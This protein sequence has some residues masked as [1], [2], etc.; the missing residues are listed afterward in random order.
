LVDTVEERILTAL[1]EARACAI[2]GAGRP[3]CFGGKP[4]S[5]AWLGHIGK[6]TDLRVIMIFGGMGFPT[7]PTS[8]G[9]EPSLP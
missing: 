7:D 9:V 2:K 3:V 1:L 8:L 6:V 4:L 5:R